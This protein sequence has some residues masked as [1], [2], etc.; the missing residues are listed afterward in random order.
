MYQVLVECVSHE[1][2]GSAQ[3]LLNRVEFPQE[4]PFLIDYFRQALSFSIVK[5]KGRNFKVIF[6]KLTWSH[7]QEIIHFI[8][9]MIMDINNK[10]ALNAL[11]IDNINHS[12]NLIDD[13]SIAG[14]YSARFEEFDYDQVRSQLREYKK[15]G[16]DIEALR[17]KIQ[18]EARQIIERQQF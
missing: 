3:C 12:E 16:I 13:I 15:E 18:N 7:E 2:L 8:R 9:Q 6:N 11:S 14:S 10:V 1:A 4:F 17:L 5:S